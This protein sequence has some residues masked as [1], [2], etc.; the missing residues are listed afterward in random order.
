M[1]T[2]FYTKTHKCTSGVSE[3]FCVFFC[4]CCFFF[5]FFGGG[6]AKGWVGNRGADLRND[7]PPP[8]H[9]IYCA[10][11]KVKWGPLMLMGGACSP[12]HSYTTEMPTHTRLAHKH[13]HTCICRLT[14]IEG[15][16]ERKTHTNPKDRT[17]YN[18]P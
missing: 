18:K 15:E 3:F 1:V 6:G 2:Y 5:F 13:I 10:Q 16:G 14:Y 7:S 9:H 4:C 17:N 12:P 11:S 8:P